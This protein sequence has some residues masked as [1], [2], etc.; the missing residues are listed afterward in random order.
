MIGGQSATVDPSVSPGEQIRII[1]YNNQGLIQNTNTVVTFT[2]T[3]ATGP[4]SLT[5]NQGDQV[6]IAG[7]TLTVDFSSVQAISETSTVSESTS[8]TA[9]KTIIVDGTTKT[10]ADIS[11]TGT[12]SG[13]TIPQNKPLQING[14]V[15]SLTSGD[16]VDAV[17]TNINTNIVNVIASKTAND[18]LVL[19]TTA[20]IL[21]MS[22]LHYKI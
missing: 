2:G 3:V 17:I 4:N 7:T 8:V 5:S 19:D 20:G 22:V 16:D 13:P 6:T 21:E 18:E 12:V 14:T 11:V 10:F 15:L 1:V 9:G